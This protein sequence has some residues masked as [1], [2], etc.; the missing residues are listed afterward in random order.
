MI[1]SMSLHHVDTCLPTHTHS[2]SLLLTPTNLHLPNHCK[3]C[4]PGAS[5]TCPKPRPI[6]YSQTKSTLNLLL[7]SIII[8]SV[9][10][11]VGTTFFYSLIVSIA[12]DD[13]VKANSLLIA[14]LNLLYLRIQPEIDF[15]LDL[16]LPINCRLHDT[17]LDIRP[18][19]R[20][21]PWNSNRPRL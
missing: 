11:G 15:P 8:M 16:S 20:P 4:C 2:Y 6:L 12:F 9:P 13:E 18:R 3:I 19:P 5:S 7:I 21:Q 14:G 10:Y 1:C 17:I